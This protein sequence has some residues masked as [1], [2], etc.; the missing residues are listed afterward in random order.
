MV[1]NPVFAHC[2]IS[3]LQQLYTVQF[4]LGKQ[5][6]FLDTDERFCR[7]L[8]AITLKSSCANFVFLTRGRKYL[9]SR[10]HWFIDVVNVLS[11]LERRNR[12][13]IKIIIMDQRDIGIV[14]FH[15]DC[16]VLY[17]RYSLILFGNYY[18]GFLSF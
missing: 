14:M 2:S 9:R 18:L 3:S 4:H 7:S 11:S 13:L 8:I 6:K 16:P 1:K 15:C 12:T 5:S 10:D 17:I